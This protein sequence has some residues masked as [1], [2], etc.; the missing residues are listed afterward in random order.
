M[1]THLILQ[2]LDVFFP[3]ITFIINFDQVFAE[4]WHEALISLLLKLCGLDIAYKT[5]IPLVI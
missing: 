2:L 4:Y 3:E 1:P 5:S